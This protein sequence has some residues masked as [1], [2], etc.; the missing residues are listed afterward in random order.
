MFGCENC[1]IQYLSNVSSVGDE[2]DILVS[3]GDGDIQEILYLPSPAQLR[4][5]AVETN[6]RAILILAATAA[7]CTEQHAHLLKPFRGYP[8]YPGA[9]IQ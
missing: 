2:G 6:Q 1:H 3:D 5:A 7:A 9:S 8:G 4:P